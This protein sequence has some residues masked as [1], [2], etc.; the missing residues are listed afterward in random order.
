MTENGPEAV[1]VALAEHEEAMSALYSAYAA[2]YPDAC[3]MWK[4]MARE[5]HGHGKALRSLLEKPDDLRPFADPR[6][7]DPASIR[8]ETKRLKMLVRVASH[9][10][11]GL[12][13]AFLNAQKLEGSLLERKILEPADDDPPEVA[14][15]LGTLQ[16]QTARHQEHLRESFAAGG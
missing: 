3:E 11:L 16:E 13:E 10:G 4:T 6:R 15:V 12:H 5:E 7:F 1:V 9:A 14:R 8:E 2:Q